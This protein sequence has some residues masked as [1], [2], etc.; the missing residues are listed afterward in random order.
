MYSIKWWDIDSEETQ[1]PKQAYN[2]ITV[3]PQPGPLSLSSGWSTPTC[4]R[5]LRETLPGSSYI[6]EDREIRL[7]IH[8]TQSPLII[9]VWFQ[10]G[11]SE[12]YCFTSKLVIMKI[13]IQVT[14]L[15]SVNG[16][17]C[18]HVNEGQTLRSGV[19]FWTLIK[20]VSCWSASHS[21]LKIN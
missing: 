2:S 21:A 6:K 11:F 8:S 12:L 13:F 19:C 4:G 18:V 1:S 10:I 7:C 20:E 15:V 14:S 5:D 16:C 3:F 17:V 9:K